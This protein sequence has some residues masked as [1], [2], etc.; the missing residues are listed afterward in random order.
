MILG[1]VGCEAGFDVVT[2]PTD[3]PPGDGGTTP[4]GQLEP[5]EDDDDRRFLTLGWLVKPVG[6]VG[7]GV[8]A[9]VKLLKLD[10]EVGLFKLNETLELEERRRSRP[11]FSS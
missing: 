3:S 8:E 5:D 7:V 1:V 2:G 10:K 4:L 6:L 11:P 9:L